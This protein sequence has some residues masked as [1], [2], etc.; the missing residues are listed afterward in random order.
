MSMPFSG[1]ITKKK[2]KFNIKKI[3][4]KLQRLSPPRK[5]YQIYFSGKTA[6]KNMS[7]S[8]LGILNFLRG[9]F[10]YKSYDFK[11]NSPFK[12]KNISAEQ[13]SLMP[14]YYIMRKNLGM[15]QTIKK[16]MPDKS[17][18]KKLFMVI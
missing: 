3:N 7:N 17:Q 13:L 5:H 1:P 12:L 8:S 9:Y 18:I 15:S 4:K 14:E 6:N 10:H 16:Y 11:E 2:N